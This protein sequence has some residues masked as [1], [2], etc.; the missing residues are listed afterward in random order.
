M[1]GISL[2]FAER[3]VGNERKV[4]II[5]FPMFLKIAK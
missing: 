4:A 3:Q 5:K 2:Q 1:K